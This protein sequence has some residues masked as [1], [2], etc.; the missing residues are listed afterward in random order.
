MGLFWSN[1]IGQ[2]AIVGL[3]EEEDSV[4]EFDIFDVVGIPAAS[5]IAD[6]APTTGS[7]KYYH[8][9]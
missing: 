1:L 7:P 6:E 5:S 4:D 8:F 3:E 9:N 2:K